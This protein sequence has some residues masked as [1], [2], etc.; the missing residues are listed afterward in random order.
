MQTVISQT[1]AISA[2]KPTVSISH[3]DN[4]YLIEATGKTPAAND[5]RW[6]Y[7]P[8][9]GT[10]LVPTPSM[11]YLWHKAVTF[12]TDGSSMEPVIEFGGSL[13]KNGIDYDLVPSASSILKAEDGTLSPA[14]IS[15]SLI[16]READGTATGMTTIPVGYSIQVVK[17]STTSSYALGSS[18]STANCSVIS[19]VLKYGSVGIE[20]HDI[21]VIAEGSEGLSGRGIQSQ[22]VRFKANSDGITPA[23]PV[24]DSEWNTWSALTSAGYSTEKKYLW[25][26]TRTVY[27][28]GNGVTD[29][30]YVVDGPTVWGTDGE[31]AVTID[32]SNEMDSIPADSTGTIQSALVLETQVRL[33]KG[34]SL[35][36]SGITAPT[37]SSIKLASQTPVVTESSGVINIKWSFPANSIFSSNKYAV[38]I[39]VEF[40]GNTYNVTYTASVVRSGKPGETAVVYEL[41]PSLSAINVE[42]DPD[43]GEIIPSSVALTCGYKK[44]DGQ[45]ISVVEDAV[46]VIDGYNI[47]FRRFSRSSN[48]WQPIYYKYISYKAQLTSFNVKLYSKVQFIL[49][50]NTGTI[51]SNSNQD[52]VNVTGLIDRETVPV[53]ADGQ[54]GSSGESA[55]MLDID[56][57]MDAVSVLA[58][59][60][61]SVS[62]SWTINAKAFY[63]STQVMEA[64]GAVFTI[65]EIIGNSAGLVVTNAGTDNKIA[66]GTLVVSSSSGTWTK[67]GAVRITIQV[68]HA[69]YGTRTA[70]FTLK[71]VFPGED[72]KPVPVYQLLLSRTEANFSRFDDNTLSPASIAVNCGF[73]RKDGSGFAA[74]PGSDIKNLWQ[75]GGAPYNIF[76][77]PVNKDGSYGTWEWMKD[78]LPENNYALTIPNTTV[79]AAYEFIL[80]AANGTANI[81]DANII[82]RETLP[83]IIAAANGNGILVDDIYLKLTPTIEPPS[84]TSLTEEYGWYRYGAEDCPTA[85]TQSNPFLW[86]CEHIEYSDSAIP[87]KNIL[88]LADTYNLSVQPNLLE[89]SAFDSENVM[90]EWNVKNGEVVPQAR[91]AYNA[92]GCWP[93][94]ANYREML[95]QRLYDPGAF[96][97]IGPNEWYTLSFFSR[98]RRMVAMTSNEHGFYFHDIHLNAGR[99]KLQINGH[100]SAAAMAATKPVALY[101][102]LYGSEPDDGAVATVASPNDS[103]AAS[104]VLEVTIPGI[105]HVGFYAYKDHGTGGD[106]GETVTANW[107]RVIAMDNDSQFDTYLYPSAMQAGGTFFV[108]GQVRTGAPADGRVQWT[109]PENETEV[110]S[111]GWTFH[112]VTFRTKPVIPDMLQMLLFRI[113][114]TYVEIALPKLEKAPMP[115]P[116]CEHEYDSDLECS[117]NPRGEWVPNT[118]YFYCEGVRDV[119]IAT[120]STAGGTAFFR[121]KRRTSAA[122]YVSST[123]PCLDTEHWERSNRL[124]FTATDLL[125]AKEAFIRNLLLNYAKARDAEG[126]VTVSIDGTTGQIDAT[127]VIR[128]KAIYTMEGGYV[129]VDGK[130]TVDL[131]NNIGNSYVIPV[132]VTV[133]LPNPAS[134]E[135]LTLTFIFQNNGVLAYDA[136][137][138]IFMAY[139]SGDTFADVL[140]S[141]MAVRAFHSLDGL[142]TVTIQALKAY[143]ADDG[144]R[145]ALTGQRGVLGIRAYVGSTDIYKILPDGKI[146]SRTN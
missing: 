65:T 1:F 143:G 52:D 16:K 112:Y 84:T 21:R 95:L 142:E 14:S 97:K 20:R 93:G 73:T 145:W 2:E 60:I 72:G 24:S 46:A 33:H 44:I 135:G 57:E 49:C 9:G 132:G 89:Q 75:S 140:P 146:L 100:C 141:G 35:V 70:V 37:A 127:G 29:T 110:D 118:A 96:A 18:V 106:V 101:G 51:I 87:D 39:Q 98:T 30:T 134:Y 58:S 13:G 122:G 17:D 137:D 50:N 102:Y 79:Y 76:F 77:R 63:G 124:S 113:F 136:S 59:G 55:F 82:D 22:D 74:F 25:R 130:L 23:A 36:T 62:Q 129:T 139:Y 61:A 68:A 121:L 94:S 31:S 48:N 78:T 119:V 117:H 131:V 86:E 105:Y 56:N 69:T 109:S 99:Y 32:L 66:G 43:T 123:Q 27:V 38:P 114:S 12:L 71:P 107:F 15:C 6:Q 47:Y 40:E 42:R 83:V 116:W 64:A 81:T 45:N 4:Y 7:V 88:R 91:G 138:G 3:T 126:N 53:I 85:P 26:C 90:D 54:K 19:F 115:T 133:Y 120:A 80:S 103:T 104:G 34:G 8:V 144:V 111:G 41:L 67:G 108:D 128:T 11:P 92:Y 125:L 5:S 28:D 10:I